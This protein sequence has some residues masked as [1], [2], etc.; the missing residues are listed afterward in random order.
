MNLPKWTWRLTE[1]VRVLM[2][3]AV[4]ASLAAYTWWLVQ[5]SPDASAKAGTQAPSS[6]PDYVLNH[7]RVERFTAQGTRMSLLEGKLMTHYAQGGRLQINALYL[8]TQNQNGARQSGTLQAWANDGHYSDEQGDIELLGQARVVMTDLSAPNAKTS[9]FTGEQLRWQQR[10]QVLSTDKP[11]LLQGPQGMVR[12][13]RL[14]HD[15]QKGLSDLSGR[16]TGSL[17]SK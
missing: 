2:P 15:A 11:V 6:L 16:V 4:A 7:A 1:Q 17:Q 8:V 9:T 14:M 10:T 13:A 12:G 3:V 5:S